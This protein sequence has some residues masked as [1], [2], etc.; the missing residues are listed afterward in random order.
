MANPNPLPRTSFNPSIV[1][2]AMEDEILKKLEPH[3]RKAIR[4][5]FGHNVV[6]ITRAMQIV[7]PQSPPKD[8]GKCSAIWAMLN[9]IRK[10]HPG[11]I[12]SLGDVK[13]IASQRGWNET[14]TR[15]QYY[16]W[17]KNNGISGRVAA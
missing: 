12:P 13:K 16:R 2:S 4:Q 9:D 8:G 5:S 11:A 1:A 6:P 10:N 15:V 3:L 17:R 7:K 14:T